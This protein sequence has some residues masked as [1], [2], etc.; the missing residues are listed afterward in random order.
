M[1]NN[2]EFIKRLQLILSHYGLSAAAFAD[3]IEVQ[4][5]SISHLLSGRNKPSLDFVLKVVQT[6]SEVNL[7]W[8]LN[9]QG[10]FP[11]EKT[12][13]LPLKK[14]TETTNSVLQKEAQEN[15]TDT[16]SLIF[17]PKTAA[18]QDIEKIIIFYK[19]GHCKVYTP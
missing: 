2:E 9:G 16:E 11:S 13:S 17:D 19:Q 12:A 4:R 1:V 14:H 5:S 6:Y 10:R 7:Y 15:P 8:L 3:S 18:D